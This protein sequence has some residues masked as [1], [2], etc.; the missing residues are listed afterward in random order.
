M[1]ENN[2]P[3]RQS[4]PFLNILNRLKR[5]PISPRQQAELTKLRA[6]L[7]QD[8]PDLDRLRDR[9][10]MPPPEPAEQWKQRWKVRS[11][12]LFDKIWKAYERWLRVAS[13]PS[14]AAPETAAPGPAV[15][16]TIEPAVIKPVEQVVP[17]KR[18]LPNQWKADWMRDNPQG[19]EDDTAYAHRMCDAM[20][21]APDV[22]KAW[23][24][25]TCRRELYRKPR[26]NDF[27][28]DPGSVQTFP[29][30]H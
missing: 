21:I 18:K 10:S 16:P 6:H 4:Q 5:E 14:G 20:A 12:S 11:A 17:I 22:T 13:E 30:P 19:D 25:E 1:S 26:E 9:L 27:A 15:K 8:T 28:P 24:F 29:K 3:P 7:R 23:P 2:D